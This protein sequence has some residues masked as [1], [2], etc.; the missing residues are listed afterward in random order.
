M[1]LAAVR[2]SRHLFVWLQRNT[3]LV[4][5]NLI[6]SHTYVIL[7]LFFGIYSLLMFVAEPSPQLQNVHIEMCASYFLSRYF[8]IIKVFIMK[9]MGNAPHSLHGQAPYA[10]QLHAVVA[11]A[12]LWEQ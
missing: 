1:L 5:L 3:N 2:D 10:E 6:S 11:G 7:F 12:C 9:S 4:I 8:I